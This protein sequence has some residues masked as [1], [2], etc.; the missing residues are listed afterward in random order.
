MCAAARARHRSF[1]DYCVSALVALVLLAAGIVLVVAGAELLLDGLLAAAARIGWTPFALTVVL[2]GAELE[3]VAA[4]VAADLKG[5]DGAA[6]GT[7]LG[8]ATFLALGV[9]G[10]GAAISPL[11]ARLP[12]AALLWTALS[13]APLVLLSLDGRLSRIDGTVLLAWFAVAIYGLARAAPEVVDEEHPKRGVWR[14]FAGIVL[15][16]GAGELLGEGVRR[17]ADRLSISDTLLGNTVIAASVEAEEVGRVAVPARRGRGDLALANVLG[18]IV[19][20]VALNA[21]IIA[22]VRPLDLDHDTLAL[23][24]PVAALAPPLLCLL[25]TRGGL[26]R[27]LGGALLALYAFYVAAAVAFGV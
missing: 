12:R 18:T 14:L 6:A 22:L 16:A 26:G 19:H 15:L 24:L 25:L 9:A 1:E 4:G 23:H 10:V 8:G 27:A 17:T 3:N 20:F 13:P 5:L 11:Q 2:S 7:F 21:G